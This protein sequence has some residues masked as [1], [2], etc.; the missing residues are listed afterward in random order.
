[1]STALAW[2]PSSL[3][4]PTR[5][6]CCYIVLQVKLEPDLTAT[7]FSVQNAYYFSRLSKMVYAP[8]DEVEGMLKGNTT[9]PGM[10]FDR[11]HWFE[12]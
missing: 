3:R 6:N 8:K 4:P 7:S 11:F 5:A 2:S 1:M 10:G 12:V 9:S